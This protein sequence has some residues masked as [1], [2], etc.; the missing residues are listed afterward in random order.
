[1]TD[2]KKFVLL[3]CIA[4]TAW[5]CQNEKVVVEET[6][7]LDYGAL[8]MPENELQWRVAQAEKDGKQ[9]WINLLGDW[10][11]PAEYDRTDKRWFNGLVPAVKDGKHGIIN[12]KNEVI[13]PFEHDYPPF[14]EPLHI[15]EEFNR[16]GYIR[17]GD[18]FDKNA[19]LFDLKGNP[20][21]SLPSGLAKYNT[22]KLGEFHQYSDKVNSQLLGPDGTALLNFQEQPF[23]VW[24][25]PF[26]GDITSIYLA[27]FYARGANLTQG[28]IYQ[29][30]IN[31]EG[32]LVTSFVYN[33]IQYF[34][35]A[36][37]FHMSYQ[38]VND[39]HGT[40]ILSK[41]QRLVLVNKEGEELLQFD[42]GA[43]ISLPNQKGIR[44]YS[45]QIID[46]NG[47]L[48]Y[49]YQDGKESLG[50]PMQSFASSAPGGIF[51][52]FNQELGTLVVYGPS[53][54]PIFEMEYEDDQYIFS[55]EFTD[56]DSLYLYRRIPKNLFA[57]QPERYSASYAEH[58]GEVRILSNSG[59]FY[60]DWI[61]GNKKFYFKRGFSIVN[62][63]NDF[64]AGAQV[65]ETASNK[66]LYTCDSCSLYTSVW[67]NVSYEDNQAITVKYGDGTQMLID[68]NGKEF[69]DIDQFKTGFRMCKPEWK[70][71]EVFEFKLSFDEEF[72]MSEY[73]KLF[74]Y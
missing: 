6:K 20:M 50:L 69:K 11:I 31:K 13:I 53:F 7:K 54:Q 65:F 44:V 33:P 48:L 41:N 12:Y 36:P 62:Y 59:D 4:V 17:I 49:S 55:F 25:D 30:L 27:K 73:K 14:I 16:G 72:I 1:M 18:P 9:G 15:T 57:F 63:S 22:L 37:G 40:G 19:L 26:A 38:G 64:T 32:E 8:K 21:D 52:I 23:L 51:P 43:R 5:S 74:P 61:D 10:M 56:V 70:D 42:E 39:E 29:A 24:M 3:S 45:Q 47:K 66:V 58:K 46:A 35:D 68:Y 28:K 34:G 2:M 60:S 67:N 71:L